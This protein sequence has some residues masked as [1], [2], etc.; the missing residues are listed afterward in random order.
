MRL[1]E[2]FLQ[3]LILTT[4][5]LVFASQRMSLRLWSALL[6]EGLLHRGIA[7]AP[8]VGQHGRI[9][10]LAPQQRSNGAV[11]GGGISLLQNPLFVFRAELAP[12]RF[13]RHLRI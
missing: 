6:R 7:F 8:P 11:S 12:L 10:S 2:F 13:G 5:L 4:Q 1:V 9:Y 3:P